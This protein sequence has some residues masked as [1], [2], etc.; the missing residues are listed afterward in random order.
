MKAKKEKLRVFHR[1]DDKQAPWVFRFREQVNQNGVLKT[2]HRSMTLCPASVKRADALKLAE[3]ESARL[4]QTRPAAPEMMVILG[5]YFTRVYL[6]FADSKLRFATARNYGTMV[7]SI[8]HPARI[9]R[10]SCFVTFAL[11]TFTYGWAR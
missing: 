10:A 4:A 2:V 11:R 8:L 1:N 7:G 9:L 5:D 6:P 3:K